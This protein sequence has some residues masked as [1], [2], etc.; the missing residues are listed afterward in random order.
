MKISN[1]YLHVAFNESTGLMKVI[2]GTNL[3][4]SNEISSL[5]SITP[6]N[7]NTTM[8][9]LQFIR[10]GTNGGAYLFLPNGPAQVVD[11]SKNQVGLI[12]VV[13]VQTK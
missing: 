10:Y 5:Q 1:K 13:H 12:E 3:F 7:R 9:N 2:F 6:A 8:A 4:V 11:A